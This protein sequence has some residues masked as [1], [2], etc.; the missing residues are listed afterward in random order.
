METY[1]KKVVP[2]ERQ[3]AGTKETTLILFTLGP[4][5]GLAS[6]SPLS[7]NNPTPATFGTVPPKR[8]QGPRT[9]PAPAGSPLG[10]EPS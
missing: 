2:G 10:R 3:V 4:G 5:L 1:R 9:T 7:F 6:V 8:I